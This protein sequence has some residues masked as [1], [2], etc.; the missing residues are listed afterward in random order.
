MKYS[1][2][3]PTVLVVDDELFIRDLLRLFLA[4]KGFRVLTAAGGHE[5][6]RLCREHHVDLTLLDVCMPGMD[7]MQTLEALRQINPD[8]RCCFMSGNPE[9]HSVVDL[10]DLQAEFLP[11]PLDMSTLADTLKQIISQEGQTNEGKSFVRRNPME[12]EV[13]EVSPRV[14]IVTPQPVPDR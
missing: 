4:R 12:K 7:G 5:A 9:P 10:M 8:L 6:Q 3:H 2:P 14:E 13:W 11:K 1:S